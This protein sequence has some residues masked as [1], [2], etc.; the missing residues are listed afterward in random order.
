MI[1][2][3]GPRRAGGAFNFKGTSIMVRQWAAAAAALGA[4]RL[5]R[6]LGPRLGVRL[7]VD[8]EPERPGGCV[9]GRPAG[10]P[11]PHCMV[12]AFQDPPSHSRT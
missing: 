11:E 4:V 2:S 7:G 12:P 6:C 8:S 5:F 10:R 9:Q 3:I 1:A